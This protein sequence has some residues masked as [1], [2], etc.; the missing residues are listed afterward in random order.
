MSTYFTVIKFL[1]EYLQD[2]T[3]MKDSVDDQTAV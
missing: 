1:L 2:Y 3:L